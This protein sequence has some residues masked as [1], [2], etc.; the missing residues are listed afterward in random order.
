M[1]IRL[2]CRLWTWVDQV[3]FPSLF[4]SG[5]LAAELEFGPLGEVLNIVLQEVGTGQG[6]TADADLAA[7]G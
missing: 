2:S 6:L 1:W 4:Q 7:G 5:G 3:V